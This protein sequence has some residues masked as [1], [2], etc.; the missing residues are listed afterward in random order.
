MSQTSEEGGVT[1]LSK[2]SWVVDATE[3]VAREVPEE[4]RRR[5]E[6]FCL[7]FFPGCPRAQGRGRDAFG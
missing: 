4:D 1:S 6:G 5:S 3:G 7:G 2:V